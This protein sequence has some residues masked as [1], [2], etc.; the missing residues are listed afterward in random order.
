MALF[1]ILAVKELKITAAE[2]LKVLLLILSLV[3]GRWIIMILILFFNSSCTIT[4]NTVLFNE[5][6]FRSLDKL[7]HKMETVMNRGIKLITIT[8]S[9][10]LLKPSKYCLGKENNYLFKRSFTIKS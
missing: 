7:D 8:I 6:F 2:N 1:L 4:I 3:F 9:S 10:C 5:L